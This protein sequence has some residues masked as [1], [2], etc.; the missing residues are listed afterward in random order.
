ACVCL[1]V[2]VELRSTG[3]A[4]KP[5]RRQDCLPHPGFGD[6]ATPASFFFFRNVIIL[7][8]S[9]PTVSICE[10]CC[11]S[12]IARNFLR[13]PALFSAIQFFAN[14]PDWI[15]ER[16][17]FISARVASLTTRGPRV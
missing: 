14:S 12:R 11:A 10:P 16:I 6:Y 5:V 2:F 15:S 9:A 7:R 8:S 4:G 1:Q 17:F 3:P 13:P